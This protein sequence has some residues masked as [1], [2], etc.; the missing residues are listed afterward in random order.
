MSSPA[1]LP[2]IHR[3]SFD[4]AICGAGG[5]GLMAALSAS[6]KGLRVACI[7]KVPPTRSHTVA[8]QGGINAA[9]GNVVPD[10]WRWHMYDTVR[11]GD[12]LGD[13]DAIAFMCESAPKAI[14]RL[15]HWGLPFSRDALGNIYQRAYGGQA[16]D[17]G[18][19]G[20]AYR[21]CA[22]ADRTGHALLHTLHQQC[23]KRGVRFFTEF[24]CLDLIMRPDGSCGGV[25]ALEVETGELHA[26]AAHATVL[27][28]GGYGQI[29][30]FTTASS[31]CT[32]DGGGMALRA[33]L[34]LQDMEFIQF[35]PTGIYGS[36]ILI[37]EGAR[38]EGGILLNSEGERF[39]QRY[40]PKTAELASRDVIC[41][42]ILTEIREKR[43]C[44]PQKDHVLLQ[45][46]HL[47]EKTLHERLPAITGL[48]KTFADVDAAKAP[49]PVVPTVHYTMGGIPTNRHTEVLRPT[50]REPH[51]TVPGLFAAGEA[52]C[53]SV[54]GANRLG[55]NSLLD[56]V[57]FGDEAGRRIAE[58]LG[59]RPALPDL[60]AKLL[61]PALTHFSLL[62]SA[63]GT[64]HAH[65]LRADL[66]AC[67]QNH[68][69]V[70]REG[71]DLETGVRKLESIAERL[72]Y[73]GLADRSRLWNSGF[74]ELVETENLL[75]Q[76]L[77]V[78]HAALARTESRGAHFRHDHPDRDDRRWLAHSLTTMDEYGRV[79]FTTRPV[80]LAAGELAF[81]PEERVY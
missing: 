4:V 11:G 57:V 24:L 59:K 71:A 51:A 68:A 14:A 16:T 52:A 10:D 21:A 55:C 39:M 80:T 45:L 9:L 26:F 27:A 61:E 23:L 19:G 29:Y 78:M 34:P 20:Q 66:Q 40:A 62:W 67:L 28:T 33:G 63:D 15:E 37:T 79:T 36:G 1:S 17:F 5:A 7:T 3:H 12:W 56:L 65:S 2:Q 74:V 35:H 42:A 76:A 18:R 6:D 31:I 38:G 8:A 49:I 58:L 64:E 47:G 77:T 70:Y 48:A 46:S 50:K 32:G 73:A 43:G 60:P 54:H 72:A 13:Q 25:L 69:G 41:R 75:Q 30:H 44:G 22:S 53:A 81:P